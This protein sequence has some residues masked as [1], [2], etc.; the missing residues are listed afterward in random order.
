M[1]RLPIPRDP[2]K[3]ENK[4]RLLLL[5]VK[6]KGGWLF[7]LTRRTNSTARIKKRPVG[8]AALI[9]VGKR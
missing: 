7:Y 9:G 1:V 5:R 4:I 2:Y 6:L 8:K 3:S